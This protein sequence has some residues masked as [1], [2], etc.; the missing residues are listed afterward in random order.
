[1][2]THR[3]LPRLVAP[4]AFALCAAAPAAAQHAGGHEH[5]AQMPTSGVRAELIADVENLESQYLALAEAMK[6]KYDWR[7]GE[8]VRSV[9]EVFMHVAGANFMLP[10]MV[11]VQPPEEFRAADPRAGMAKMQELEKLTDEAEIAEHL[12]HSFQHVKHAI[13]QTP[14]D[15]LDAPVKMF[16]QDATKRRVL[17]LLATHMHEHLGQSIAYARTNGVVPPWS[18]GDR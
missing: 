9:S 18:Q 7:P 11:G 2:R 10:T 6:G 3:P 12:R 1:M 13:A 17:T 16:G 5:A 15:Q 8:G 14:D 4:L